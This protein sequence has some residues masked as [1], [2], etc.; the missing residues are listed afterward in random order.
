MTGDAEGDGMVSEGDGARGELRGGNTQGRGTTGCSGMRIL[1]ESFC[2]LTNSLL[3]LIL[4]NLAV[5][6]LFNQFMS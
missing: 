3:I 2:L 4:A 1:S 6:T 5:R